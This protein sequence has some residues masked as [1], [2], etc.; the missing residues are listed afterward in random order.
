MAEEK[1]NKAVWGKDKFTEMVK[2]YGD[3]IAK[4]SEDVE[5]ELQKMLEE[6][7]E[8]NLF[9]EKS[10]K[11][12]AELKKVME[13]A[14]TEQGAFSSIIAY[15]LG[16][17]VM[18]EDEWKDL[19]NMT[20][21][22]SED[23]ATDDVGDITDA[24]RPDI[25]EYEMKAINKAAHPYL[26]KFMEQTGKN[27]YDTMVTYITKGPG[28]TDFNIFRGVFE[29]IRESLSED[30]VTR[31]GRLYDKDMKFRDSYSKIL[32]PL[33]KKGKN[34]TKNIDD[35]ANKVAGN[36]LEEAKPEEAKP[37]TKPASY[38]FLPTSS[39]GQPDNIDIESTILSEEASVPEKVVVNAT[40][41]ETALFK[42]LVNLICILLSDN[43]K[44][45]VLK[46]FKSKHSHSARAVQEISNFVNFVNINSKK[47][48]PADFPKVVAQYYVENCSGNNDVNSIPS[49]LYMVS[50]A[51]A[52]YSMMGSK[53]TSTK[54]PLKVPKA[55]ELKKN[56]EKL[57]GILIPQG[58]SV[59]PN[60][61][62]IYKENT[63]DPT[64]YVIDYAKF[65]NDLQEDESLIKQLGNYDLQYNDPSKFVDL[66]LF[67]SLLN[68]I[69]KD[70][71]LKGKYVK[72]Q[73][74]MK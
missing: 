61:D 54:K 74:A 18:S 69:I 19:D 55:D 28:F 7:S 73:G 25:S 52:A 37:E 15:D 21:V 8:V 39:Q 68:K 50:S 4:I 51:I 58:L 42:A 47:Y 59:N 35:L 10:D 70:D 57:N 48:E 45:L 16:L 17:G 26:T 56:A 40:P 30:F 11:K 13:K 2:E 66:Q 9:L 31:L 3:K 29:L 6:S 34:I 65:L 5:K 67:K 46:E 62:I 44:G 27:L 60:G 49:L 12:K 14:L 38:P 63:K 23:D 33:I 22:L 20:T 64:E 32:E 71:K 53:T 43:Y 72:Q 24:S 1:T 36:V 41:A